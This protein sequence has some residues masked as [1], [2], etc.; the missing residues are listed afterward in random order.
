MIVRGMVRQDKRRFAVVVYQGRRGRKFGWVIARLPA[1]TSPI[2]LPG[3][4]RGRGARLATQRLV[5][6]RSGQMHDTPAS[7][8]LR[9]VDVGT[10]S[11]P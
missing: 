10:N 7:L 2:P 5:S 8:R 3:P 11:A 4:P 1:A 6:I 9:S